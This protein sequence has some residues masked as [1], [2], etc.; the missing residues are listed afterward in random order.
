[1]HCLVIVSDDFRLIEEDEHEQ[2]VE[3][4]ELVCLKILRNMYR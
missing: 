1:M 4:Q 3:P 2:N